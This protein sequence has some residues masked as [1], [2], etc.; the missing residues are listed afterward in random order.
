MGPSPARRG[1]VIGSAGPTT[2]GRMDAYSTRLIKEGL[3][4][5]EAE[6]KRKIA[7]NML[8]MGLDQDTIMKATGL[9]SAE[10]KAIQEEKN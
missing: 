1:K 9:T 8:S 2:S 10:L 4:E 7:Q 3:K 6:S 5:G